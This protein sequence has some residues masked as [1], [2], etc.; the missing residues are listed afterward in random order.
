MMAVVLRGIPAALITLPSGSKNSDS[1][2][3]AFRQTAAGDNVGA[4]GCNPYSTRV[5]MGIGIVASARCE[6]GAPG[7]WRLSPRVRRAESPGRRR[8]M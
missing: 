5:G 6:R 4:H 2:S 7:H 1:L 8:A 3:A